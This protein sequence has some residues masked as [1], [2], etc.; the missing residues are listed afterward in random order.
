MKYY[1]DA[2]CSFLIY[3]VDEFNNVVDCSC[4]LEW[5]P[6]DIEIGF[7]PNWLNEITLD[8]AEQIYPNIV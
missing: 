7:L 3:R 1:Y 6:S 4:G 5:N 2:A 8:Q